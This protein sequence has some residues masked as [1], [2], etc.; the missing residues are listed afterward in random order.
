MVPKQISKEERRLYEQLA[1]VSSFD[2][3]R[4]P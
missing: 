3:R 1:K 4:Q 2:P